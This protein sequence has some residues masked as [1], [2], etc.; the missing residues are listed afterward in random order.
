VLD[1][2]AALRRLYDEAPSPLSL[3]GHIAG[4]CAL[5]T[6]RRCGPALGR[7]ALAAEVRRRAPMTLGG[8]RLDF[9]D[10]R[11]G[12]GFVAHTLLRPDGSLAG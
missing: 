7:T 4:L 11:R 1:Y 2:R 5:E 10:G 3:A 6:C 8:F 12:S 9:N